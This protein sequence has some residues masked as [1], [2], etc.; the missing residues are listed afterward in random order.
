MNFKLTF[1]RERTNEPRTEAGPRWVAFLAAEA[2]HARKWK[3]Q[4]LNSLVHLVNCFMWQPCRVPG[5]VVRN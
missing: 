1:Y 4:L 3:E 2:V 5:S